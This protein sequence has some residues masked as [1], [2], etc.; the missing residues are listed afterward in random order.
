[1][2]YWQ[3]RRVHERVAAVSELTVEGYALKGFKTD[4][5]SDPRAAPRD[6][7]PDIPGGFR[8]SPPESLLLCKRETA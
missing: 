1:M 3:I 8:S 4:A 7:R 5:F 2:S 6:E